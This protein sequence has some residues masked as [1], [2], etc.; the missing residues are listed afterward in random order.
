MMGPRLARQRGLSLFELL[1]GLAIAALVLAPLVPMLE[2]ASA[3][4]RIGGDQAALEQ[5]ADFALE[6]IGARIRA[7][8]PSTLAGP[9]TDWLKPAVYVVADGTLVEQLGGTNYPLAASVTGFSLA[10]ATNAGAQ[11]LI[12]ISL[13]LAR[14]GAS[15]SASS[16][17]RM[18]GAQ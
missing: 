9:T 11:P 1:L 18:G 5:E 15:L 12:R 8:P 3:A 17:V 10:A 2:T 16:V 14:N 6:R 13:T 7:T 4:A